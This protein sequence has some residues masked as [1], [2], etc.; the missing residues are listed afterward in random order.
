[1]EVGS[2][3]RLSRGV[4]HIVLLMFTT[5]LIPA[6]MREQFGRA[7]DELMSDKAQRGFLMP[8]LSCQSLVDL[9]SE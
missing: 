9:I 5:V 7:T 3:Q 1:M 4:F 2:E 8:P 6:E